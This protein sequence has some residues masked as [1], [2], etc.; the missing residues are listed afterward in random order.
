MK[1]DDTKNQESKPNE[2]A[3]IE[4][5]KENWSHF[6]HIENERLQFTYVYSILIIAVLTLLGSSDPIVQVSPP[7]STLIVG[8]MALFSILGYLLILRAN[9]MLHKFLEKIK[10]IMDELKLTEF[11]AGPSEK[12]IW[13]EIKIRRIFE[14]LYAAMLIIWLTMFLYL[15]LDNVKFIIPLWAVITIIL[16]ILIVF[17]FWLWREQIKE[18]KERNN[19]KGRKVLEQDTG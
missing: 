6:R 16:I 18:K 9:Y 14:I 17:R 19:R 5:F 13:K 3:L 11:K 4:A 12:G 2:K 1:S 10:E 15:I 7:Y 8:F